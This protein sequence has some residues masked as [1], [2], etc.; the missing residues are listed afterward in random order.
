M[1]KFCSCLPPIDEACSHQT[2]LSHISDEEFQNLFEPYHFTWYHRVY[3]AV[4]FFVFLGPIRVIVPFVLFLLSII[5]NTIL[6]GILH[7]LGMGD[8]F[9]KPFMNFM[10]AG[11]RFLLYSFGHVWI[12]VSGKIDP[13]ARIFISNHFSFADPFAILTAVHASFVMKKELSENPVFSL[14]YENNDPIYVDRKVSTGASK[15]IIERAKDHAR[16]PVLI[17]PEAAT[18]RA[19]YILKFHRG[20]FITDEKVQPI[21]MRH[22]QMFVPKGWNSYAWPEPGMIGHILRLLTMPFSIITIEFLPAITLKKEGKGSVEEFAKYAQLLIANHLKVK[23][24][25]NSSDD[26]FKLKRQNAN[27]MNQE[28]EGKIKSN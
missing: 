25:D 14:I 13:E 8:K 21:C 12:K 24:I 28:R 3:Q 22:W 5:V 11:F 7:L 23:A 10:I 26:H 16:P 20:A 17:F 1:K 9:H 19:E 2:E 27:Q 6:R 15:Y 18:S 4:C